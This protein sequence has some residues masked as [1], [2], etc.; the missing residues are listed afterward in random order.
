M[1]TA[2]GVYRYLGRRA[3]ILLVCAVLLAGCGGGTEP[4]F[5]TL[6]ITTTS[7]ADADEG[8]AYSQTITASGGNGTNSWTVVA[9]TL[10]PGISLGGSSGQLSGTPTS[11]GDFTFTVRATSG[12][13]QTAS[14][15]LTVTVISLFGIVTTDL[16]NAVQGEV[17]SQDV[18]AAGSGTYTWSIAADTLP[19]GLALNATTGEIS[20][21]PTVLGSATFTVEVD[22]GDGRTEQATYT[23]GV[24]APLAITTSSLP[25]AVQAVAYD[26]SVA[27]IGGDA[28]YSWS[29]ATGALPTGLSLEASTGGISGTPAV[30]TSYAFMLQVE[31]GDGQT[32]QAALTIDVDLLVL[33]PSE[34]CSDNPSTAVPTFAD[35]NLTT[36]V[37]DALGLGALQA[38]T[39]SLAETLTVLDAQN[40][41][42]S[43]LAGIH[44]LTGLDDL[45][46]NQNSVT[47]LSP[48]STLTGLTKLNVS[49]NGLSDLS[50]LS[51]LTALVDLIAF[52][53]AITDVS[54]LGPLTGIR[55]LNLGENNF[56]DITALSGMTTMWSLQLANNP[57]SDIS[58]VAGMLDV[59]SIN[60]GGTL[61][62]DLS[63][64]AGLTKMELL[65][66]TGGSVTDLS[67][68]SGLTAMRELSIYDNPFSDLSPLAGLTALTTLNVGSTAVSDLSPVSGLTAL[69][70]LWVDGTNVTSLSAIS[71]LTALTTLFAGNAQITDISGLQGLT[72]LTTVLLGFNASL[73]DIDALI[74]NTGMGAGDSVNLQGTAVLCTDVDALRATGAT[75]TAPTCP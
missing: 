58:A 22:S 15:E 46:I 30:A 2:C 4:T 75:V 59:E 6:T 13:G 31:S 68:L 32:T 27:A 55:F 19:T 72:A 11:P 71:G 44:N 38:L 24:Y 42:M 9:G 25:N 20:G 7:L 49:N 51:G 18:E 21:T 56:S 12:D 26:E 28:S 39:C 23:I 74:N 14:V 57:I 67:P 33:A 1:H 54:P 61:V 65:A 8:V 34:L 43:D 64:L 52:G 40:L 37:R 48:L 5:D 73:A 17:Y 35:A 16:P 47:D 66:V 41:G 36:A 50:P 53:N 69:Q 63:P 3:P 10:P 62:S 45:T 70:T 60:L 29:V